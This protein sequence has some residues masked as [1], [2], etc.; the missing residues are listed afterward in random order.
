MSTYKLSKTS[1]NRL[2]GVHDDLKA[3]V[4]RA[5]E[6]TPYD[7]GITEGLRS[8]ERQ[9]ELVH[10]GA[11][12]SINSRHLTGHAIDIGVYVS[13]QLTW[14]IGYYRKVIQAFV[15]AAI[16][17]GIQVEFGGLWRSFADGPHIQLSWKHYPK[18]DL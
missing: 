5:I 10:S 1:N 4:N 8:L 18:K 17:L 12:K 9:H 13:G 3:V 16:E 2:E 7:F 6:I 14:E 11:S 15:S